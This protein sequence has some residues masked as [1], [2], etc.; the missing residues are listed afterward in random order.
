MTDSGGFQVMSLGVGFKKTLAM[1]PEVRSDDVIAA[2]KDRLARVDEDGVTFR[3]HL[4]GSTHRFTPEVSVQVQHLIGADIIFAFD[5]LTTLM[6][7]REYQERSVARTQ[8]WAE[9]CVAEHRRLDGTAG[10]A[11]RSSCSAWSRGPVRGPASDG[12]PGSGDPG[13]GRVRHRRCDRRPGSVRSSAGSRPSRPT[14]PRHLLG[15]GEPEDFFPPSQPGPTRSTASPRH[16]SPATPRPI[17]TPAGSTSAAA[18]T[19]GPS[20]HW[21]T[22]A[23][24]TRVRTTAGRICIICSRPRRCW[25]RRW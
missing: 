3:S 2:G 11:R 8:R 17:T 1:D 9:R 12:G 15:I 4:D 24:A 5:E 16:G 10:T 20:S 21:T 22:S 14:K 13:S 25:R 7:T 6:N 23:T 19:D 18:A